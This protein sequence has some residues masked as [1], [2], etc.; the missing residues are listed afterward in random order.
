MDFPGVVYNRGK[1]SF[2]FFMVAWWL[3]DLYLWR[4]QFWTKQHILKPFC[5]VLEKG[6]FQYCLIFSV[7]IG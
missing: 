7:N 4:Y 3:K 5:P 1:K 2:E 6:P